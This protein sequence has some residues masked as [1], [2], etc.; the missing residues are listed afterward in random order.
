MNTQI[1]ISVVSVVSVTFNHKSLAL[2]KEVLFKL[3]KPKNHIVFKVIVLNWLI[4][5]GITKCTN[6]HQHFSGSF[7]SVLDNILGEEN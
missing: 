2:L 1:I 4:M 7:G 5:I 6:F 3:H